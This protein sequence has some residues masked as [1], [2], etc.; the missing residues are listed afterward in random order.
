[1]LELNRVFLAG[2]LVRDPDL[3]Y[4]PSGQAICTL[5]LAINN[6]YRRN[7]ELKRDTTFIDVSVWGKA[8]ERCAEF[9]KKGRGVLVEGR[10]A[11]DEWEVEGQKRSKI[12][13]VAFR[14]HFLPGRPQAAAQEQSQVPTA[15]ESPET[16]PAPASSDLP[17]EPV[18]F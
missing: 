13:V 7:G 12:K 16:S 6:S 1:M 4:V 15:V 14:V 8:A 3:R 2:N 5:R 10:L 11:Q 9:L 17:D 18:P